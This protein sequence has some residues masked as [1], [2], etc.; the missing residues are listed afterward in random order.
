MPSQGDAARCDEYPV[1]LEFCGRKFWCIR[2]KKAWRSARP[3]FFEMLT[4]NVFD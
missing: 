2:A 3:L 4:N 1:T